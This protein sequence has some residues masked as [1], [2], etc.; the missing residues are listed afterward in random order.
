MY[1]GCIPVAVCDGSYQLQIELEPEAASG[2]SSISYIGVGSADVAED[3][4]RS[5]DKQLQFMEHIEPVAPFNVAVMFS[6][7]SRFGET[8]GDTQKFSHI[9]VVLH[10]EDGGT[11][12]HILPVPHRDISRHLVVSNENRVP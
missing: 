9:V 6:Y 8:W 11:S 1:S 7:R 3:V 5:I 10:Q 2:V 12:T 4:T